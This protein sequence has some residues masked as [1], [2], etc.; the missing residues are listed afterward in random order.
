M[1]T[2][3]HVGHI[4]SHWSVT[5][6]VSDLNSDDLDVCYAFMDSNKELVKEKE[7]KKIKA[8]LID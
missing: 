3:S 7:K 2:A 8:L 4:W 6:N 1:V 5:V